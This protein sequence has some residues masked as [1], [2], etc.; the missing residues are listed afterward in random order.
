[1]KDEKKEEK[2]LQWHVAFFADLQIEL[3]EE[4]EYLTFENEHMLGTKPMQMDVLV[5]KKDSTRQIRKNIGRIFRGHNIVEYKSPTD[6]LSIDDFF[7]VYG[8][9]CFYKSDTQR[10][11]EIKSDEV[12]ITF[13]SMGYPREMCKYLEIE[14]HRTIT[15][16][17]PGIYYI[18]DPVF[19]IQLLVQRRL[20]EEENFWLKS[21][22][23]DLKEKQDVERLIV[24]YRMHETDA[25]YQSVMNIIVDANKERFQVND[26]CEALDRIVDYHVQRIVNEREKELID[27]WTERGMTQGLARGM[28]QGLAR[29]MEQGLARGMEQ[30]LAQSLKDLIAKKILKNKPLSQIADELEETEEV[31]RPLYEHVKAELQLN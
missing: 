14:L 5:I 24:E 11:N 30:G 21:L 26:M 25:R 10:R 28:E 12:T 9:A 19:P 23:N 17:G 27:V 4:A 31:I 13:V 18:S 15:E 22:T 20:S 16:V 8:Y 6:S 1:M 29:G 7:K 2:L 3:A